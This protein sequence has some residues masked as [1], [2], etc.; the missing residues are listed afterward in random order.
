[1]Q[2]K[3]DYVVGLQDM[4]DKKGDYLILILIKFIQMGNCPPLPWY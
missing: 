1:M 4:E 3:E 2:A